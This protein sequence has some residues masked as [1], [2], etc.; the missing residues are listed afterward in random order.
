MVGWGVVDGIAIG[1]V[2]KEV[3]DFGAIRRCI[4]S[5]AANA[6]GYRRVERMERGRS[7]RESCVGASPN[8]LPAVDRHMCEHHMT[9]T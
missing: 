3:D 6:S 2:R 8:L 4:C 1:A 5:T 7:G 9:V